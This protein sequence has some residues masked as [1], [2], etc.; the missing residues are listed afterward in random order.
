MYI[1]FVIREF[2]ILKFKFV[3]LMGFF[4]VVFIGVFMKNNL[5]GNVI[6]VFCG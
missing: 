3:R 6:L 2:S 5:I 1:F 4:I